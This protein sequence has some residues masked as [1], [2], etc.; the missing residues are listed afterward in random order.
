MIEKL[1]NVIDL[2]KTISRKI[3]DSGKEHIPIMFMLTPEGI[4]ILH[5]H[6]DNKNYFKEI[7]T[8]T[9]QAAN[10][11]AYVMVN[12]A[13]SAR[14]NPNSLLADNLLA[15]KVQVSELPM[16]DKEE[17]LLITVA[18]RKES[19]YSF[20][21]RIRYSCDGK[22]YLD[23]WIRLPDCDATGKMVIKEW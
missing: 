18:K 22:R 6:L 21:A 16:D 7:M 17:I 8:T 19:Y 9:L 10:A 11:C 3:I 1:D 4:C 13:W 2:V 5:L 12:E 14:V 15:G 23:K 20:K